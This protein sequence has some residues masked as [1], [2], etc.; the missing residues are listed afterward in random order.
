[1]DA[2]PNMALLRRTATGVF[3]ALD[4][5]HIV[6]RSHH[7][8]L[9]IDEPYVSAQHASVRWVGN[10]WEMKDLG[11][12]NGTLVNDVA[13][14]PGEAIR[15]TLGDRI[16]FGR[17]EQTWEFVDD[18][19]PRVMVVPLDGRGDP[20]FAEGDML[21]VPSQDDPRATVFR[22]SDGIWCLERDD[23]IAPLA[24]GQ[25]FEAGSLRFRFSCPDFV[26]ETS[27][28][29]R[30]EPARVDLARLRLVFRVSQDEEHVEVRAVV[31]DRTVELGS[32]GHNYLLLLLA[33]R[34][35]SD[36]AGNLKETACGWMYNDDLVRLL[37]TSP[38]RLNI[39][40]FR[41]RKH[42]AGI[43]LSDAA[44]IVER[45]PTTR[46]TRIGIA[47]LSIEPV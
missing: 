13:I 5:E 27:T 20:L 4:P 23:E 28:V 6:G 25:I 39:D 12:R 37:K 38:E 31:G 18:S 35:M 43:G 26:A 45:R 10:G 40:I 46:E 19:A 32:R 22:A 24:S 36:S 7:V 3:S 47:A 42:F 21:A 11:S 44:G 16:S 1:M 41:I 33:R 34:R 2:T 9:Q 8:T 15:L 14:K 17:R 30:R 29:S